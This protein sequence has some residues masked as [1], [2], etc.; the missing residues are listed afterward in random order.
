VRVAQKIFGCGERHRLAW[1]ESKK[2]S[3]MKIGIAATMVVLAL[4]AGGANAA[5]AKPEDMVFCSKA[6]LFSEVFSGGLQASKSRNDSAAMAVAAL[7]KTFNQQADVKQLNLLLPWASMVEKLPG[8]RPH[9][10]GAFVAFSCMALLKD[11]KY[12]PMGSMMVVASV[13]KLLDTC[14]SEADD[15]AVGACLRKNF[16]TLP[17]EKMD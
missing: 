15:A 2:G 12:L 5:E 6:A 11:A 8:Y 14:E 7:N 3:K 17:L 9:T 10:G 4:S 13:R 1:L 16:D